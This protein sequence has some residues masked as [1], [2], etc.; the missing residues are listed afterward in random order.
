[1]T[2]QTLVIN[3]NL[4]FLCRL[5]DTRYNFSHYFSEVFRKLSLLVVAFIFFDSLPATAQPK[6]LGL[7]VIIGEP[8]GISFKKWVNKNQAVDGAVAWSFGDEDAFHLHL[9]YLFH[10][11]RLIQIDRNSIPF[12]YGIGGRV[13]FGEDAAGGNETTVSVRIPVG[14][15]YE[16]EKTP[17]ELFLEFVPMLDLIPSTEFRLAGGIGARYYF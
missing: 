15:T 7:G 13:K 2:K 16:F 5:P 11:R 9:D 14:L 6:G 8:T 3:D 10:N 1:M 17:I 12:Y 4:R